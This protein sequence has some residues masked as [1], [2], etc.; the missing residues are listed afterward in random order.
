MP[1][2]VACLDRGDGRQGLAQR[3]LE[4]VTGP[5]RRGAQAAL[6]LRPARLDGRPLRRVGGQ[7]QAPDPP[8]RQPLRHAHGGVRAAVSPPDEVTGGPRGPE[9]LLY[10]GAKARGSRRAFSRP[11]GGEARRPPGGQH[12]H[13][14]PVVRGRAPRLTPLS[15]RGQ[16]GGAW[17]QPAGHNAHTT[18]PGR[19]DAPTP[20]RP[21]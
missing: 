5:R 1:E 13:R 2:P 7:R 10:V 9:P 16:R 19:A 15:G 20:H 17:L 12:R 3:A 6:H 4:G 14:W 11:Q 8:P 21:H 18:P